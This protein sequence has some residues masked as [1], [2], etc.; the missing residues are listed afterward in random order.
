M[1]VG[2]PGAVGP[3]PGLQR[4]TM[5][6]AGVVSTVDHG[7]AGP[8]RVGRIQRRVAAEVHSKQLSF[9]NELSDRTGA[10][11]DVGRVESRLIICVAKVEVVGKF[12][13][14]QFVIG[15]SSHGDKIAAERTGVAS[16]GCSVD[17]I[18]PIDVDPVGLE[19]DVVLDPDALLAGERMVV[20]RVGV[21]GGVND[22]ERGKA[23]AHP[24]GVPDGDGCHAVVKRQGP[25]NGERALH[26]PNRHGDQDLVGKGDVGDIG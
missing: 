6:V 4:R 8:S 13:D 18:N 24:L 21:S 19:S 22:L 25:L 26:D 15:V 3:D 16:T 14:Q 12:V 7:L 20:G 5:V 10:V 11:H 9:G 1:L 2:R 17:R 23:H